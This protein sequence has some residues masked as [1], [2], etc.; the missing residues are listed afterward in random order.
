MTAL[1]DLATLPKLDARVPNWNTHALRSRSCPI[2][3]RADPPML[4]RPDGLPVSYCPACAL[5]YVSEIPPEADIY[6]IYQGYWFDYRPKQLNDKSARAILRAAKKAASADLK[7]QRLTALIGTLKGK[8]VLEVGAGAGEFI[9]AVRCAGAD[10]IAND[11]SA[12]SCN[13]L[14]RGLHVPVVRGELAEAPWHF[15]PPDV[16]VMADLV[17]HPIEPFR[18]LSRAVDLLRKG[19]RLVIWTPNGGGAGHEA[20]TAA[21]W[22]GFRVDLEHLQYFSPRTIQVLANTWGLYIDHLE[23]TGYPDLSG[24]D[25]L[26]AKNSVKTIKALAKRMAPWISQTRQFARDLRRPRVRGSYHLFAILRKP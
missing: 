3:R 22:V 24:I 12:E 14:E 7:I 10:V 16:I 17:E 5:W 13:F 25:R 9:T 21:S 23:T 20:T 1:S 11:I 18:L 15:G 26:P 4:R 19:G 6:A 8:L 2:C